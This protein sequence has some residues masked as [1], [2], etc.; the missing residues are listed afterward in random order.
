MNDPIVALLG[1][2]ASEL[3]TYSVLLRLVLSA[4]LG[5]L[6]GC[7]RA[8]KRH[9]AG[10]RT[11]MCTSLA[12]T[13]A[14]LLEQYLETQI[15]AAAS[16]V[17]LAILVVNSVLFSARGRIRGLTTSVGLWACGAIGL[18]VGAGFYTAALASF[19]VLLCSLAL[20]PHLEQFLKNRSNHFEIHVE[21][22]NPA[23]L[24]SFVT[25][26]RELGM[27][28]DDIESNPAYVHSGLSV[29]SIA[30]RVT[31]KELRK[32]MTHA[33]IIESLR[34]LEYVSYIEELN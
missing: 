29:Y 2:W 28:I 27:V 30:L 26:V 23:Y 34:T 25:T 15:L 22:K 10:L 17:G 6:L 32:Y 21:L 13:I 11:F 16:I 3:G 20:F 1:N 7:E 19:A 9:A 33:Q 5:A 14:M 12:C 31:G 24:Q 8:G 18:A 4:T